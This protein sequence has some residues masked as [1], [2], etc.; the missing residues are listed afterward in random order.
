MLG[1]CYAYWNTPQLIRALDIPLYFFPNHKFLPFCFLH[2]LTGS[3]QKS[4]S[5][6]PRD[7]TARRISGLFV[8]VSLLAIIHSDLNQFRLE[9]L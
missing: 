2:Q 8:T 9:V 7:N 4:Y 1:G 5:V 3:R 6:A